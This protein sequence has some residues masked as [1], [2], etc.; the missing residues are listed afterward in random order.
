MGDM[1]E[2]FDEEQVTDA[3]WTF[4]RSNTTATLKFGEHM[5]EVSYV[6]ANDGLLVIP[7]MVAMLQLCDTV[8]YVPEY[9]EDCMEMQV[10]LQEFKPEG[11]FGLLADRWEVYHGTPPDVQWASVEIDA[12]RFHDMFVDGE[13]LQRQNPLSHLEASMCKELNDNHRTNV[14]QT[15]VAIAKIDVISPVVV[16]VDPLGLDVRATFG[17]VR[18][19]SSM[20]LASLDDV[21]AFVSQ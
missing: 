16:G 19:P 21:V 13:C 7:A 10:S 6:I 11:S 1:L 2:P 8:M 4:L 12:A 5:H 17:I 18:I 3:A 9:G 20:P 15:C 14:K